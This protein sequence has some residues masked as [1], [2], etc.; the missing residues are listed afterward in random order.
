VPA[1]AVL[2]GNSLC[3]ALVE[4]VVAGFV[5]PER[6]AKTFVPQASV[7]AITRTAFVDP[8]PVVVHDSCRLQLAVNVH[9]TFW[10]S[11]PCRMNIPTAKLNFVTSPPGE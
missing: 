8:D 10:L 4:L 2:N 11:E 9:S 5:S 6:D 7:D 3:G 1:V